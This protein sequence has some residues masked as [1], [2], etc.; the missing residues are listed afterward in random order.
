MSGPP[1]VARHYGRG[2][3]LARLEAALADDGADPRRPTAGQLAPYDQ[4]H[5]RGLEATEELAALMPAAPGR[6]LLDVGAGIGGPARYLARRFGA[7]VAGIDLTAEFCAVARELTLRLGLQDRVGFVLGDAL[8]L[9]FA[10]E[11]FD[12]ACSMNVA[13]NVADKRGFY[14]EIR[15]VLKPAGW[16]AL[17][18]VARGPGP[19]PQYPTPWAQSAAES[20]LA[21]PA[22]TRAAL[23]NEGFAVVAF[24]DTLKQ[25]LEYAARSRAAVD[26]GEK[27]PHRAVTLI[28]GARARA[29]IANTARGLNEGALVPIE[30]LCRKA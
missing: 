27:P 8:A 26:R 25:A 30:V 5:G 3:L 2:G 28:H 15:R 14:R 17:S 12:G 10:A 1:N 22:D 6:R 16:F 19:E 24:R 13:M 21:A 20:F 7:R 23:E 4:F 9:P 29:M 11:S 18:E